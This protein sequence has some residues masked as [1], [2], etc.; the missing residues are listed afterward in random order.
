[1]VLAENSNFIKSLYPT[2]RLGLGGALGSGRQWI[3]WIHLDDVVRTVQFLVQPDCTV[4]NGPVNVTTPHAV[5]QAALSRC[6]SEAVGAPR[7]PFGLPPTPGFVPRLLL[8]SARVTIVLDGQRVM[9]QKLLDAGFQFKYA[10]L[11][12]ALY[13]I[14]G[15]R[16]SPPAY[17]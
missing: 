6:L 8:G 12:D 5:R 3:S 9:P 2:H 7:I 11:E 4:A 13:A 14:Y 1:M 16:P 15:R 17:D 10:K